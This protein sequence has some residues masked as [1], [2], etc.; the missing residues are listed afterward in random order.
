MLFSRE[1]SSDK[2]AFSAKNLAGNFYLSF[3]FC[4]PEILSRA[5]GPFGLIYSADYGEKQQSFRK[6]LKRT[7]FPHLSELFLVVF[8]VPWNHALGV[9]HL[10]SLSC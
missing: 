8:L 5:G 3:I 2:V 10:F 9:I 7:T 4:T 1:L 6:L